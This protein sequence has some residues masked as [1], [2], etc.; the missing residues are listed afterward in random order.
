MAKIIF[1]DVLHPEGVLE[2]PKPAS[3]YLPNWYKSAQSYWSADG[4]KSPSPQAGFNSTI[5]RCMPIFDML[6]AGYIIETPYDI[7]VRQTPEGPYFQ[8][9]EHE[10]AAFVSKEQIQNHPWFEGQNFGVRIV[11]PWSIKTPKGW[12]VL[13]MQPT[14]RESSI[15]EVIPG[16]VDTDN[17]SLPFNMFMRLTNPNF[18]G[19]IPQGTP[20]AQVIPLKRESWLSILG[21]KKEKKKYESDF[22]KLVTVF[23]DRYKKFW[24]V[25]KEYK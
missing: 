13:I 18:E 6:T 5:K 12:S 10:A 8:W 22:T 2:K 21:G 14:H 17:Y 9:N 16:I 1:T 3:E 11:H 25:K 19:L 23:F 7:Y 4:K 24:W 20:F 15:I